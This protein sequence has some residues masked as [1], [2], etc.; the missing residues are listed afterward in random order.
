MFADLIGH[1]ELSGNS[2]SS[3]NGLKRWSVRYAIRHSWSTIPVRSLED[4]I[5][6]E[7][8]IFHKGVL[9]KIKSGNI[10]DN[11][12][13]AN[14]VERLFYLPSLIQNDRS[15]VLRSVSVENTGL[16]LSTILRSL[17]VFVN[18]LGSSIMTLARYAVLRVSHKSIIGITVGTVIS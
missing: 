12:L 14:L 4:G 5:V 1:Q 2:M 15:S 10:T 9:K 8:A 6:R 17:T 13:S 7:T 18:R 3:R 11:L 16:I